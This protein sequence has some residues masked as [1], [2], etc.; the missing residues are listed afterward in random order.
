ME[1]GRCLVPSPIIIMPFPKVHQGDPP[2]R[3]F[4]LA[5]RGFHWQPQAGVWARDGMAVSEEQ[6][7]TMGAQ[8]WQAFLAHL[9]APGCPTCGRAWALA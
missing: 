1:K 7:D 5:R 8:Q 6:L 3:A 9:D 2:A 4:A